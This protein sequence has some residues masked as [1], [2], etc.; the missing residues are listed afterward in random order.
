MPDVPKIPYF[1]TSRYRVATMVELAMAKPTDKAAD[2]GSGDGRI[3]MAFAKTGIEVHG[4]EIDP[5]LRT[6]SEEKN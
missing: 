1:Q 5:T 3:V 6:L 2:L 4:Y